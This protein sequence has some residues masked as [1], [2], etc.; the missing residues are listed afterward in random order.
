MELWTNLTCHWSSLTTSDILTAIYL[1]LLSL[2]AAISN[3]LF[4]RFIN[5][6]PE[7]RKTVLGLFHIC[8]ISI[9]FPSAKV[10]MA[11]SRFALVGI[12]ITNCPILLRIAFGPFH[13]SLVI[14]V[15]Y[16]FHFILT[17]CIN[18]LTFK[19]FLASAFI[20]DFD[21]M[22]GGDIFLFLFFFF[23]GYTDSR[24][25]NTLL[26][27]SFASTMF[28][29]IPELL[30]KILNGHKHVSSFPFFLYLGATEGDLN[31]SPWGLLVLCCSVI[32]YALSLLTYRVL[33]ARS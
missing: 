27:L 19:T 22:S 8:C 25:L 12:L 7:G 15:S 1:L 18:L 33:R 31:K 20:V 29:F 4:I 10:N 23:S 11:I 21:K 13:I 30:V 9:Y 5:S 17:F 14:F 32:C 28:G 2:T 24:V 6:K 16:L 3:H 26:L